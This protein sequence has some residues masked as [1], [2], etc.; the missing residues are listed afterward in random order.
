MAMSVAAGR[1]LHF[2]DR[3]KREES[4]TSPANCKALQVDLDEAPGVW[5][6]LVNTQINHLAVRE[7]LD[8]F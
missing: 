2:F 3:K 7:R 4:R 8:G 6:N 1:Q 5:K